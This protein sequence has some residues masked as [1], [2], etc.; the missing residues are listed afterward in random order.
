MRAFRIFARGVVDF[1][2]EMYLLIGVNLVWTFLSAIISIIV[3]VPLDVLVARFIGPSFIFDVAWRFVENLGIA[4]VLGPLAI[5]VVLVPL[6]LAPNPATAGVYYVTHR[7]ARERRVYFSDFIQGMRRYFFRSLLLLLANLLLFALLLTNLLFYLYNPWQLTILRYAAL[8]WAYGLLLWVEMQLYALPLLMEQDNKSILIV[9][10]NAAL[11]VM[12]D[13]LYTTIFLVLL[14]G[15]TALSVFLTIP[16][17]FL[18]C[19]LTSMVT[20]KA[21]V[22][23]VREI[24]GE[25]EEEE[26]V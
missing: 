11:L 7:I 20:N 19:S 9:L 8:M 5:P 3:F 12:S 18:T 22:E 13:P 6:M 10:R 21:L 17:F 14:F 16:I 24:R 4:D 2:D 1:Y 15:T 25:E 26:V 23:R